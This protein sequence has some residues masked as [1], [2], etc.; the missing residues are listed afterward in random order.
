MADDDNQ[1][2]TQPPAQQTAPSPPAPEPREPERKWGRRDQDRPEVCPTCGVQVERGKLGAHRFHAHN[3][4]RR[5]KQR[6]KD[7]DADRDDDGDTPKAPSR[8]D[9]KGTQSGA[10]NAGH[11][12][13]PKNRWGDVRKGWG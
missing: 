8:K 7:D 9:D 13:T 5:A 3:E 4:D 11:R 6:T 12:R 2:V 1:Q 10:D